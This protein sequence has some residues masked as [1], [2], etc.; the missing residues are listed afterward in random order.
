MTAQVAS[1]EVLRKAIFGS[2]APT[3]QIK[4]RDGRTIQS[5]DVAKIERA[6]TA[7]WTCEGGTVDETALARVVASVVTSLAPG[8]I[9]VEAVQDAVELSLMRHGHFQVAKR[10]VI[11]RHDRAQA[12]ALRGKKP[13]P[14]AVSDYIVAGKYARY[15]PDFRRREV[16]RETVARVEEMHIGKFPQ[17]ESEIRWAF[18]F[19]REMKVLPSMRSM[20]FA[21]PAIVTN[22]NRLFNCTF[23]LI[24]RL[25]AFSQVFYLL[26]CGSGV[27]YSV[28][29]EHVE[30]LPPVGYVDSKKIRHHVVEDT[31]EGCADALKA[32]V[33]SY[34]EGVY[35]EFSYHLIRPAGAPL[36]VS[37]GKAPGHRRFKESLER[38]RQI[39]DG[40]QGRKLRPLECHRV[41]AHAADAVLSGGVRRS[42]MI[43]LFSLDDSEMMN[44]KTGNWFEKEPWFANANNSVA[45][46][47]GEVQ[48]KQF[49]R[50]FQMTKEFGEPAFVFV[51]DM[52]SGVNP[53]VEAGLNPV[54][55]IDEELHRSLAAKGIVTRV[56]DT[57]TGFGFCNLCTLNAAKFTSEED[58]F[59]AARAAALIGTLQASYTSM[60]YLGWVSEEI[61]KREALLG[62]SM[63]GMLD[64]PS[65]SCD[66]DLQRRVA[67][68]INEW[69]AEYAARIGV[70]PAARTTCLKPEGTG[71]LVLGCVGSGHHGHHARRYIRRVTADELEPVFQA[72]RARN[73]HA[74]LRKP[75]GKWIIEFPVEAPPGAI[76]K[77]DMTAIE[78]LEK[79]KSTQQNWVLPGTARPESSPGVTHN[80]SNTVTVKPD[81][82]DSVAEYL[83]TNREFFTG[84][85][86][87]PDTGDKIYAFAP[88][89]EISTPAD[90]ARW[91]ALLAGYQP[92]DY[93][94]LV[95][96]DDA[97]DLAAEP[98]CAGG[99]CEVR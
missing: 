68:K 46:K 38:I 98:A 97:T 99:A 73:P 77:S 50:I 32:L 91:N 72:Y 25:E 18:D 59:Q 16:Y 61:A 48:W 81:E 44:C 79:V 63:T 33:Q 30:K 7:A 52:N 5:F 75:D 14:K 4:K 39:L 54:L 15:R 2:E 74:C 56:G 53:C 8:V 45:L 36:V 76:L 41:L 87:L 84:V 1:D 6:V 67:L 42:A 90:E 71:S 89:E 80:V 35:L 13:D 58:F 65:I 9:G 55:V 92:L 10:Y 34:Q 60:P 27:G 40:A 20:Q 23:T 26:F 86:L 49:R 28:Q 43:A 64:A 37:G 29:F 21:G 94:T 93:T 22:H 96:D 88:L 17:L 85:S 83:W 47:R 62:I 70:R 12:R 19:V 11:Y 69:N 3:G 66:P 57:H 51:T 78:F 24:D 82:W 31:I 95:E